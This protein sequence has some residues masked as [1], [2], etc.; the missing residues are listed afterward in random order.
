MSVAASQHLTPKTL[1]RNPPPL[2]A[3]IR[4]SEEEREELRA[5][6]V[7]RGYSVKELARLIGT[8]PHLLARYQCGE[9]RPP[10][11]VVV[12]WRKELS[13]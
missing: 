6:R 2:P 4:L 3:R 1:D 11:W 7:K 13:A 10:R 9:R 12:A 8:D 5:L